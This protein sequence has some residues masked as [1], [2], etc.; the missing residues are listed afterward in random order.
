[1]KVDRRGRIRIRSCVYVMQPFI[2]DW[3]GV[4]QR[5]DFRQ[6]MNEA[7]ERQEHLGARKIRLRWR[8]G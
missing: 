7:S 6:R 3:D 1:M 5:E 2:F 8:P 4:I